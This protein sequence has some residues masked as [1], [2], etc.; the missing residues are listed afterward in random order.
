MISRAAKHER[1]TVEG[2]GY[3][4]LC[5]FEPTESG[6]N[7]LALAER[8]LRGASLSAPLGSSRDPLN[9]MAPHV[10]HLCC[11]VGSFIRRPVEACTLARRHLQMAFQ[12]GYSQL[13]FG[14]QWIAGKMDKPKYQAALCLAFV[15]TPLGGWG[16]Y[17]QIFALVVIAI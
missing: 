15:F 12:Q 17:L 5:L 9:A 2:S 7:Q 11:L 8:M 1:L 6:L 3:T 4:Q 10:F 16:R 13:F 14:S